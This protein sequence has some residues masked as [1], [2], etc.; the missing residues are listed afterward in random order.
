MQTVGQQPLI[1]HQSAFACRSAAPGFRDAGLLNGF[2]ALRSSGSSGYNWSS[3]TSET[4]SL[5]LIFGLQN[6]GTSSADFRAYG[7]Q[8][9]C[10]SE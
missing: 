1:R 6:L 5:Y 3:G 4:N 9:R 7:L 10:L 8:L 2:G